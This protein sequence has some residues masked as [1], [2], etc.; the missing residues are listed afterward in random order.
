MNEEISPQDLAK[1]AAGK[2]AI[3]QFIFD[4]IKIGLGSGTTSHF[5]V[6]LLGEKVRDGLNI[7]ATTTSRGTASVAAEA[8]IDILDINEIG[9]LDLT[10]D[11]PDEID[12]QF[13][14]IK[15]GGACLL[16]EKIVAHASKKMITICDETKLVDCL[17]AFPLPVE[18]VQFGWQRTEHM[19]SQVLFDA[20]ITKADIYQRRQNGAPV[21]T[22]SGNYIIDCKCGRIE[23]PQYLEIRLNMIPG[24]VENGLFTREAAG[25]IVGN[26]NQTTNTVMR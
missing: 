11:G 2:A 25:M 6:R 5:F 4:G 7:I 26:F 1:I 20:G 22:D 18:V 3:E 14:M 16:W 13:R 9:E 21:I 23:D 12:D 15:G 10:I 19:I 24:V 17:G 8:G